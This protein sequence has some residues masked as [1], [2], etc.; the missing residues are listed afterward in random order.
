MPASPADGAPA[1]TAVAERITVALLPKVADE[2]LR[3]QSRTG[4]SKTDLTNRAITLYGYIDAHLS[5]GRDLLIR[6]NET[7]ETRTVLIL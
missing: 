5:A 7:G 3:L 6:D 2:L 4:L 1:P